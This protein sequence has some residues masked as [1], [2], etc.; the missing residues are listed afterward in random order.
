MG[1]SLGP[2]SWGAAIASMLVPASI[3]VRVVDEW[4]P[5]GVIT[6]EF[7]AVFRHTSGGGVVFNVPPVI[8]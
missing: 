5:P 7:D 3:P 1:S 6:L 8:K 4:H 2:L